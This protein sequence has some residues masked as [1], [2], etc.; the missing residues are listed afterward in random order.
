MPGQKVD[1]AYSHSSS[2]K[3]GEQINTIA[4]IGLQLERAEK[5]VAM[6]G[7]CQLITHNCINFW[8]NWTERQTPDCCFTLSTMDTA[9]VIME[10]QWFSQTKIISTAETDYNTAGWIRRYRSTA[11]ELGKCKTSVKT[12]NYVNLKLQLF[13]KDI[14]S[15]KSWLTSRTIVFTLSLL[16]YNNYMYILGS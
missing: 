15:F 3:H 5:C 1:W 12:A 9:S 8:K 14:Y 2:A 6:L 16:N 7:H 10:W 13:H 4:T 11:Y